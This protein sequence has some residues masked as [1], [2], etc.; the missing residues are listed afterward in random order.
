MNASLNRRQFS[1]GSRRHRAS[2][3][4]SI[5]TRLFA[6]AAAAAAGQPADQPPA[7]CVAAHQ[8]RRHRHRVHRQG[9]ARA[10]HPH[11]AAPDRRRGARP[12]ARAHRC[13]LR[14]H[15]PHAQRGTDGRQP[16]G[17]EQRHGAAHGGRGSARHPASSS[18]PS[19]SPLRADTLTVADGVIS[20]AGRPQGRLR[21]ACRRSGSQARGERQGD[22]E[23]GRR[24]TVSSASRSRALTSRP[25]SPAGL[26]SCRTCG[27]PAW[28]MAAWCA[29]RTMARRSSA[30]TRRRSKALPGV[31]A[32]VR[33]GSFLGVIAEREEQAVKARAA[34]R[35]SA[36]WTR[37]PALPD[38][39]RI[40]DAH[41][42]AHIQGLGD[43]RQ[44]GAGAAP[45]PA[46]SRRPTPS[47]TTGAW[48]DRPVG[49]ARRIP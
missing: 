4:R 7:R 5:P 43:R 38:P 29:R 44:A 46:C 49:G 42:V 25:R 33:D 48:L 18:P 41:Q 23:A 6:Q 15:R 45:A 17:R 16:V 21:G 14:R 39:A 12:A 36:Q 35:Q 10:G 34:L 2:P 30:S 40:Y 22:A 24:A 32:V 47:P 3:S 1:A 9:R 8:S 26:R 37:G 28:C 11:G 19:G 27:C 13:D 20:A 31:I